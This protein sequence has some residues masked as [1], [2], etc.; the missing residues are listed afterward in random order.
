[1]REMKKIRQT[2]L[3]VFLREEDRLKRW[4]AEIR[5]TA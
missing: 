3:R 1:M 2:H 5:M 4:Y